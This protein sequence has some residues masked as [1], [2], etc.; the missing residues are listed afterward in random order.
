[1]APGSRLII[2]APRYLDEDT[3]AKVREISGTRFSNFT[4]EEFGGLAR[5]LDLEWPGVSSAAAWLRG[6]P[7]LPRTGVAYD[8]V[9]VAVKGAARVPAKRER[10]LA[11]GGRGRHRRTRGQPSPARTPRRSG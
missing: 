10:P 1:M 2:A 9:A 5:G 6:V 7:W 3:L 11:A 8:L 4:P